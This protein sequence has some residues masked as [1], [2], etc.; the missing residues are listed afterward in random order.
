MSK[1]NNAYLK[2]AG[3]AFQMFV[4]FMLAIF[5]GKKLDQVLSLEQPYMTIVLILLALIAYIYKLYMD[6]IRNKI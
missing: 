2:Y 3:M 5:L 6:V 4:L 1:H